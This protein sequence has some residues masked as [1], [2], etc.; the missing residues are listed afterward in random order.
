M[1]KTRQQA[2]RELENMDYEENTNRASGDRHCD[3][4]V[5]TNMETSPRSRPERSEEMDRGS[6]DNEADDE[7]APRH[8]YSMPHRP[9]EDFARHTE[10]SQSFKLSLPIFDGRNKWRTFIRQY[11]AITF[12]WNNRKKLQYL[13]SCLQGDAA[14]FVF[15]LEE[16]VLE[17]YYALTDE[18]DRRFHIRETRQTK[19]RKFYSRKLRK[20]ESIREYAAD[21]KRLIRE[22]YPS[23]ISRQN[24][25]DMSIRQFFDGLEDEDLR[26]YVD[27]LKSP[28]TLDEAVNL[29]YE[30]DDYRNIKRER[31][32]KKRPEMD[33]RHSEKSQDYKRR[34]DIN[35][36]SERS[37]P[38]KSHD[39]PSKTT[40]QA[41]L[42]AAIQNLSKLFQEFLAI[43]SKADDK[44]K[45]S[46]Y[47]CHQEGHYANACPEKSF[48]VRHLEDFSEPEEENENKEQLN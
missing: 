42:T 43:E 48:G 3:T 9:H 46:C 32:T 15:N 16:D 14:D 18:L 12:R 13:L 6:Y 27:Y 2:A 4:A 41:G 10:T 39:E 7:R 35:K 8:N 17:D 1:M 29:V 19:V 5:S 31:V 45:V 21:L 37:K 47:K 34:E 23:G 22:A 20:E 36:L 28:E 40:E 25:E 44:K 30:Y 11:E 26:Y 33:R 24:Q 38:T